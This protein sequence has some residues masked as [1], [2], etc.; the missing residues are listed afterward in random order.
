MSHHLI[1]PR[2][3]P[4]LYEMVYYKTTQCESYARKNYYL[5]NIKQQITANKLWD[6][7]NQYVFT[8][9][10]LNYMVNSY[11]VQ[12]GV[13]IDLLH[14]LYSTSNKSPTIM[15]SLHFYDGRNDSFVAIAT[16]R[17][18]SQDIHLCIKSD[19]VFD[20]RQNKS[21]FDLITVGCCEGTIN[22]PEYPKVL[23]INVLQSLCLQK[24]QGNSIFKFFNLDS[25]LSCDLIGL[26]ASM[27]YEIQVTKPQTSY[28]HTDDVFVVCKNFL[29][30]NSDMFFD[31][32]VNLIQ[33]IGS[34][35]NYSS[36]IF[37]RDAINLFFI[38]KLNEICISFYQKQLE[39]IHYTIVST[40]PTTLINK[41]KRTLYISDETSGALLHRQKLT[42]PGQTMFS[43]ATTE[44]PNTIA[45]W[46]RKVC[47]VSDVDT[48]DG[49]SD[50]TCDNTCDN[51]FVTLVKNNIMKCTQWCQQHNIKYNPISV[52]ILST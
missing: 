13:N 36:S 46:Q 45:S 35:V 22:G 37:K 21:S 50:S 34:S 10:L 7:N 11:T 44:L 28:T 26:L 24:H 38:N 14:N 25:Q 18:N 41:H 20:L 23:C 42:S 8:Y 6:E 5:E 32:F 47:H 17:K 29:P 43:F 40:L 30:I 33:N 9:E 15:K 1:L 2:L 48:C 16:L 49:T 52:K 27:Y 12:N 39:Y 51:K 31:K 4:K 19:E 3:H